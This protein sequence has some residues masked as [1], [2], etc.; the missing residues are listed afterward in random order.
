[1]SSD[2]SEDLRI[3]PEILKSNVDVYRKLRNTIRFLL[4]NLTHYEPAPRL[5]PA[6]MPELE[7]YGA[8]TG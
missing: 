8:G 7:R 5:R 2:Y 3:G 6:E 1:M 4:S